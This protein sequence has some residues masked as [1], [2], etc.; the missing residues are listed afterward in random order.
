MGKNIMSEL[1]DVK[2]YQ[3]PRYVPLVNN[4]GV[5]TVVASVL[6]ILSSLVAKTY[7]GK[8]QIV[9]VI[10]ITACAWLPS[11]FFTNKYT[12]KYPQRYFTYL[13]ASHLKA[14]MVMFFFLWFLEPL[15]SSEIVPQNVL[16]LSFLVFVVTDMLVSIPRCQIISCTPSFLEGISTCIDKKKE[17]VSKNQSFDIATTI[18]DT[19]HAHVDRGAIVEKIASDLDRPMVEFIDKKLENINVIIDDFLVLDD[20][21]MID[22]HT[23]WTPISLLIG[24][25]RIND[26]RRLNKFLMYCAH[27]TKMG[28]CVM[29]RY[30]PLENIIRKMQQ[31]YAG[32]AYWIVYTMHFIWY[33][34]IPKIPWLD[35]LYFLPIMSWVDKFYIRAFKKRNRALSKAEVWGRLAFCGMT[36]IEESKGDEEVFI[37]AQ[38]TEMPP[39]RDKKPSYYPIVSLEKVGLD[40]KIIHVHK[41]RTMFPFSEFLQKRIFEDHGLTLGGKFKNDFRLTGLGNILRKYWLDELPQI[42]DWLRGDVKLVGIRATSQHFLSLYPQSFLDLYLQIKPGLIPPIFDESTN[43]FDQIVE[44]EMKYLQ[45]YLNRPYLTDVQYFFQTFKDIFI[46]GIRSK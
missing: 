8:G 34:A 15:A 19:E 45:L 40:G 43:T 21:S 26:V 11:V 4:L 32:L 13:M 46:R 42:F 28:G 41:I 39:V 24:R 16:L 10:L 31:N 6:I 2:N 35:T 38:R 20:I 29:F 14:G 18:K 33:R 1:S 44:V 3:R 25:K 17:I 36:I 7:F 5:R 9:I 27:R 22:E 37:I 12:H 30:V 23:S